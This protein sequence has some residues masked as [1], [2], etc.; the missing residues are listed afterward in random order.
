MK[1]Q[2]IKYISFLSFFWDFDISLV[3]ERRKLR[4]NV[5]ESTVMICSGYGN[6]G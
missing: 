1:V 4:V 2:L 3:C 6:G 5:D